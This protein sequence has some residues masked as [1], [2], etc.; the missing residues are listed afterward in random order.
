MHAAKFERLSDVRARHARRPFD[1]IQR[2]DEPGVQVTG[3]GFTLT[4]PIT[5]TVTQPIDQTTTS[6]DTQTTSLSTTSSTSSTS[7]TSLSSSTTSS[8]QVLATSTS[9]LVPMPVASVLTTKNNSNDS[10]PVGT[11]GALA[12]ASTSLSSG[13]IAAIAVSLV[14][15]LA[16]VVVFFTR[17]LLSQKRQLQRTSFWKSKG[18][19]PTE[20]SYGEK[21]PQPESAPF[22]SQT[23][24]RPGDVSPG[25]VFAHA[26]AHSIASQVEPPKA[27][28]MS[29]NNPIAISTNSAL[30]PGEVKPTIP[31]LEVSRA[32]AASGTA[33]RVQYA[34]IPTLPDEL[35]IS[36][37]EMVS[38][39]A[40]YDDGWALC[41]NRAGDKGMVPLECLEDL[42][43]AFDGPNSNQRESSLVASSSARF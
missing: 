6:S 4:G 30:V 42:G 43:K 8:S 36:T 29:Y 33:C 19:N 2:A 34:F 32:T 23:N 16:V 15:V 39:V 9:S 7:S 28:Q 41:E 37:G 13:A 24:T 17:R 1:L 38:I 31:Y 14:V 40:K 21:A 35:S 25:Y 26:Q 11:S 22:V 12:S 18:F 5:L 10:A 3:A 20:P 27:P